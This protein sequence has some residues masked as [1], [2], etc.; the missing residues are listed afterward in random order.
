MCGI[1]GFFDLNGRRAFDLD[2]L[3]ELN[4]KQ[5][6]R[7]PDDEGY[8]LSPG[9]AIAHRRLSI[10]DL[11]HGHQPIFNENQRVGV[12]FNG[13]IYNY[14][15]LIRELKQLGHTFRTQSDTEVIVHAWEQWGADCVLRF[16]G[17]FA[18]AVVDLDQD[19]LFIAR[20]RMGVK[21]LL[22]TVLKD[23]TFF[24]A[25]DLRVLKAHPLFDSKIDHDAIDDFITLG[26][27]LDP[28]S[29]YKS[30]RKL[31]CGHSL[32]VR[33]GAGELCSQRYWDIEFPNTSDLGKVSEA[34][35]MERLVS[36]VDESVRLRMVSDV[37]IGAFLS[38]GVDSSIV[39]ASMARQLSGP[40]STF[41][42]GFDHAEFDETDY[43]KQLSDLYKTNH[44][45]RITSSDDFRSIYRFLDVFAEPFADTSAIPMLSVS[46][47]ASENLKVVLSGDGADELFGGYRRH[48]MHLF[49]C[50]LRNTVAKTGM[51]FMTNA[52]A[53]LYPRLGWAPQ[54]LRA[55]TTLESIGM[56]PC[57]AYHHAVSI[58]R[59]AIRKNLYSKRFKETIDGNHSLK[60]FRDNYLKSGTTDALKAIQ[61][62]DMKTYLVGDINTK[63]DR[64]SMAYSLESREPL[65]DHKLAEFAS[66]IPSKFL[67]RGNEGKYILKKSMVERV[68]GR[69]MYRP[70]M[71]FSV[72]LAKWFRGP[73]AGALEGLTDSGFVA[74]SGLFSV[75]FVRKLVS[76]HQ[77]GLVNHERLLASLL[78]LDSFFGDPV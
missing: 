66:S 46:E 60:V 29:I 42:I 77:G 26:Y 41:S 9:V 67:I 5:I 2:L 62:V 6:A 35:W 44:Y 69:L 53:K 59:P 30:V 74:D 32:L 33:R 12:V 56:S 17:M 34:E 21:P 14:Q 36:L 15:E 72:P 64:T 45:Q 7:G 55:K 71:G 49:E 10:I 38:G 61:Y 52:L 3:K 16:R 40:V 68:P 28:G 20:D 22:Y 63:V 50:G 48:R 31:E 4:N 13:E 58:A 37:P 18:F 39:V 27:I 76:E 57:D 54:F 24:F 75:D 51:S 23:G 78:I 8:F 11:S 73:L 25:S 1:A 65:M 19:V 43:A 47:L 70:K